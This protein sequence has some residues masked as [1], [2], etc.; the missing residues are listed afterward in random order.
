[1]SKILTSFDTKW[2]KF[3]TIA[4]PGKITSMNQLYDFRLLMHNPETKVSVDVYFQVTVKRDVVRNE[5]HTRE[6]LSAL[7]GHVFSHL[8]SKSFV[9]HYGVLELRPPRPGKMTE[10]RRINIELDR[11]FVREPVQM[12]FIG[13]V[14]SHA[15]DDNQGAPGDVMVVVR[16]P[17][18]FTVK[19]LPATYSKGDIAQ[20]TVWL[21]NRLFYFFIHRPPMTEPSVIDMNVLA[22]EFKH[23]L[24]NTFHFLRDGIMQPGSREGKMQFW[25]DG[26]K[27]KGPVDNLSLEVI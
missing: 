21:F 8:R 26:D 24:A 25:G 20:G 12:T 3:D 13:D 19:L 18:G 14:A 5:T 4:Y 1:M 7:Y 27:N 11:I 16:L 17:R 10:E 6:M 22:G 2:A 15:K 23:K 9:R